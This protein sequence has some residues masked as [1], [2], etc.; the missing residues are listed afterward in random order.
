LLLAIAGVFAG[1][2][3]L[4]VVLGIVYAPL[5]LVVAALFGAVTYILYTHGTG[6]LA[7]RLYRR[8]ERQAAANGGRTRRRTRGQR[9]G[10]GGREGGSGPE[11]GGFG[12][13]PREE[14]T[15]PRAEQRARQRR[16]R[17]RQQQQQRQ[18]APRSSD[19]PSLA[20]AYDT[21]GLDTDADEE[22]VKAAYREKVKDVHPDTD[23][24]DEERFKEVNRAYE[25]LTE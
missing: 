15:G 13:G 25:R 19:R 22:A 20:E 8:V 3:A 2:T 10:T 24:G 17:A 6:K 16:Q 23:G 5:L 21:L 9:V 18:R 1:V 12:A 14:W 11:T 7:A 4:F